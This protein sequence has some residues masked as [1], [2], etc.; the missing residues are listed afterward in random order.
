ME[1]FLQLHHIFSTIVFLFFAYGWDTKD[2]TNMLVKLICTIG[3]IIGLIVC[4]NDFR[5]SI[6]KI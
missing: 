5:L 3:F 1:L 4:L 6:V 2:F